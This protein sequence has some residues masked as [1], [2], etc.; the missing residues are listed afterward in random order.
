METKELL[1]RQ[2]DRI[3]TK[4]EEMDIGSD[5]YKT[6]SELVTKLTD[7]LNELDKSTI[8]WSAQAKEDV[9]LE[10]EK[11]VHEDDETFKAKQAKEERR[12]MIINTVVTILGFAIPAGITVWG[13][14]T[15][16]KFEETGAYTSA[17]GRAFNNRIFSKK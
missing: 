5:E 6:A 12:K 14:I 7:R 11:K 13:T 8:Q 1:R 15:S 2:I 9:R 3:L 17:A 10:H 16:L 4:M